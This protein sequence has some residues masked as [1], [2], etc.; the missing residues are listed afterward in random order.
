MIFD[1][2]S[3]FL[4]FLRLV[5]C[6]T[7]WSIFEHVPCLFVKNMY[8]ISWG[9][10][11]IFQLNPL[12]LGHCSM[13]QYFC[14]FF[15]WN[16][17]P[18]FAIECLNPLLWMCCSWYFSWT[19]PIFQCQWRDFNSFEDLIVSKHLTLWGHLQT[20]ILLWVTDAELGCLA[21]A[22]LSQGTTSSHQVAARPVCQNLAP[23]AVGFAGDWQVLVPA[24]EGHPVIALSEGG[25]VEQ[26]LP[27]C[28]SVRIL[29]LY[30]CAQ[31]SLISIPLSWVQLGRWSQMQNYICLHCLLTPCFLTCMSESRTWSVCKP[32][33]SYV[34]CIYDYK[35]YIFLIDYLFPYVLWSVLLCLF[36]GLCWS[37]FC[38]T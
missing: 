24:H 37:L 9:E 14:W 12:D 25:G 23:V 36:Y 1:M 18:L 20:Q 17:Y 31:A 7:M 15:S 8:F 5:L 32:G 29:C 3:F 21:V 35:D 19:P 2:I 34:D 6:P 26:W 38:L 13:P 11:C 4:N 10:V 27:V 30:P 33:C 16:I 28:C 22:P